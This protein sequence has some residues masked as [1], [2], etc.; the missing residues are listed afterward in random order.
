MRLHVFAQNV[1]LSPEVE[2]LVK[3]R[4]DFALARFTTRISRVA[5]RLEDLNGPRGGLDKQCRIDVTLT[6]SG[7]LTAQDTGKD[8]ET[9]I[10]RAA[11]KMTR[12]VRITLDRKRTRRLHAGS[13]AS[14]LAAAVTHQSNSASV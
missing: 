4:L 14:D 7:R 8:L 10:S 11:Q 1:S 9:A 13:N 3:R 5:V 12:R 2:E 6:R